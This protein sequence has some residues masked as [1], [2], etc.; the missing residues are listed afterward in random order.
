MVTIHRL[1]GGDDLR[2]L[3]ALSRAFFVEYEAHDRVFFALDALD[4]GAI[5]DYFSSFVGQEDRAAFV[6][7][8]EG[9]AVGYVTAYVQVQSPNWQVRRVG[10][11]S[12]LMVQQEER[13]QGIGGRLL[14]RVRAFFH[15]RGVRYYTLYTAVG[16]RGALAFYEAQG[17]AP[18][19]T[20]LLGEIEGDG[21]GN[22]V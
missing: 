16:N 11:I 15:E 10:H 22:G 21:T 8:R 9:R 3:V 6:A 13:R 14:D 7:L 4:E 18:L 2:D 12:G 19:Y 20:H 1:Q 5:A 17:M